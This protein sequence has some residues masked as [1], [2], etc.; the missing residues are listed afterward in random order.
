[1]IKAIIIIGLILVMIVIALR[2][3]IKWLTQE[4]SLL[5]QANN[6]V[7]FLNACLKTIFGGKDVRC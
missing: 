5:D 4:E 1:M 3:I 6:M 2:L 7:G